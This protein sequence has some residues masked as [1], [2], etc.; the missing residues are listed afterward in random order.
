MEEIK[1]GEAMVDF[2]DEFENGRYYKEST[3]PKLNRKNPFTRKAIAKYSKY[4]AKVADKGGKRRRRKT[5]RRMT[6]KR[7]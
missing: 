7:I 5:R 2:Q 6:R 3:F 1:D 4:T